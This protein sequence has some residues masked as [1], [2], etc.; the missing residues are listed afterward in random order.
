MTDLSTTLKSDD[1]NKY[2]SWV[3]INKDDLEAFDTIFVNMNN[4][5]NSDD[6]TDNDINKL[7]SMYNKL[8]MLLYN[9]R[10][11]I[12]NLVNVTQMSYMSERNSDVTVLSQNTVISNILNLLSNSD[13][14]KDSYLYTYRQY[15]VRDYIP[16]LDLKNYSNLENISNQLNISVNSLSDNDIS[17]LNSLLLD[18]GL[19]TENDK[20]KSEFNTLAYFVRIVKLNSNTGEYYIEHAAI[21]NIINKVSDLLNS[22]NDRLKS[23]LIK[24]NNSILK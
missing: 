11:S 19:I 2:L 20:S 13:V 4:V 23:I 22:D 1:I 3:I 10:I 14:I 15:Y 16:T 8:I 7:R 17:Y 18:E 21:E 12:T 6:I 5:L 24:I 9:E